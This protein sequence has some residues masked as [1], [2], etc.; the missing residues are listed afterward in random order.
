[1]SIRE[2]L[3]AGLTVVKKNKKKKIEKYVLAQTTQVGDHLPAP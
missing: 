1:M 3:A 2:K